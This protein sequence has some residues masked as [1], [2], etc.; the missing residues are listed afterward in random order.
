MEVKRGRTKKTKDRSNHLAWGPGD[1]EY[2]GNFP[3]PPDPASFMKEQPA[4]EQSAKADEPT[5]ENSP[6]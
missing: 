2:L 4:E 5:D 1:L 6:R 3:L